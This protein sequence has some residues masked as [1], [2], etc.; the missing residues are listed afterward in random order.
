LTINAA[1]RRNGNNT[2]YARLLPEKEAVQLA[3]L[4]S[5]YSETLEMSTLAQEPCILV[6]YL[7]DLARATVKALAV[8]SVKYE[9]QPLVKAAR[10][11]LF[12]RSPKTLSSGLRIL[13]IRPV[14]YM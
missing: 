7:L 2:D 3:L 8:L 14:P 11:A 6:Q 5:R 1:V 9:K 13:K 4:I 10:Y 12:A